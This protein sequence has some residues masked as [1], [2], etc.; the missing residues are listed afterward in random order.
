MKPS[1]VKSQKAKERKIKAL[2][3]NEREIDLL[4]KQRDK[5]IENLK[6]TYGNMFKIIVA[7][8]PVLISL[9]LTY[10]D[11]VSKEHV[12]Y[13]RFFLIEFIMIFS[14]TIVA[15]L[16]N[17]NIKR[18]YISAVDLYLYDKYKITYLFYEGDLSKEDITGIKGTFPLTTT[19]IGI[20]AGTAVLFFVAF[21]IYSDRHFYTDSLL[22]QAMA[23]F[24]LLQTLSFL[25]IALMNWVRKV[26]KK[27]SVTESCY[28]YLNREP[29]SQ[30]ASAPPE[31]C[32]PPQSERRTTAP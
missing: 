25:A 16:F 29:K 22:G 28:H 4:L 1:K 15:F 31:P 5:L 19:L 7:I 3:Q 11:I 23:I 32:R 21:S 2:E 26:T 20:S 13:V 9:L 14:M 17:G 24:I 6:D 27:S 10:T 18:D 8:I 30:P 12:P